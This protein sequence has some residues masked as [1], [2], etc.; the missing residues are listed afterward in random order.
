MCSYESR[1]SSLQSLDWCCEN[2][3]YDIQKKMD[4]VHQISLRSCT[5]DNDV[6]L[7][8]IPDER[9]E[10]CFNVIIRDDYLKADRY[11][12]YKYDSSANMH[13]YY[14]KPTD[15]LDKAVYHSMRK[16]AVLF[17]NL[18]GCRANDVI[19][20]IEFCRNNGITEIH[21]ITDSALVLET[22]KYFLSTRKQPDYTHL[23]FEWY[24]QKK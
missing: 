8:C 9:L 10:Y 13:D 6:Y 15:A 24:Y 7:L 22:P 11:H 12:R 20:L 23:C 5:R 1:N 14:F 2:S 18:Y 16:D 4:C 17:S 3:F 19:E 21:V